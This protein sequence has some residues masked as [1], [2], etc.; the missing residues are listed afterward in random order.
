MQNFFD[1]GSPAHFPSMKRVAQMSNAHCGPAV[2]E[3]LFSNLGVEVNQE[4]IVAAAGVAYKLRSHG[5]TVD[6]L[7]FAAKRIAPHLAFWSKRDSD[8]H[9]L[10]EI[11][12]HHHYPVGVE[13]QG[14]F[15]EDTDEDD[16]HYGIVTHV[17]RDNGILLLAD[18][19]GK[20]AGHDRLFHVYDFVD[21]WWD[22]N[23]I[24]DPFSRKVRHVADDRAL[25]IV[26]KPEEIF[27]ESFGMVRG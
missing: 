14:V 7:S 27:P 19:Y 13:W 12:E 5:M 18:P 20:F 26:T 3:M 16:G 17:D 22:I 2:V 4:Q 8:A 10:L 6:E 11:V 15:G 24:I 9:E 23:E 1:T 21:R 25:F